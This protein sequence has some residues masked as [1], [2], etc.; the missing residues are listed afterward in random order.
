MC[1]LLRFIAVG[2]I[3]FPLL[4]VGSQLF[5]DAGMKEFSE[6]QLIEVG[7]QIYQQG[8]LPNGEPVKAI[9]LGNV[10]V[11]GEQFTC[12]NCHRRSGLGGP[13]GTKYVLPANGASLVVP[14]VDL[15][16]SRPAYSEQSFAAALNSGQNPNGEDFDPIMPRYELSERQLTALFTYLKTL[17]SDFSPGLTDE[18]LNVATI[19][20]SDVSSAD[21]QAMLSVINK[22]FTNKNA[23]TRHENKRYASGPFYQEY[24]NKAYRRWN[25]HLWELSGPAETWGEQLDAYYQ[26]QPVFAIVSGM[27]TGSWEPIHRFSKARQIPCILPNT[28]LPKIEKVND[29]YTLYYS[30]GLALEAKVLN[31][32]LVS[33]PAGGKILQIYRTGTNGAAAA[34]TMTQ[35]F[36]VPDTSLADFILPVGIFNW[37]EVAKSI[38]QLTPDLLI[39][40]LSPEDL[41]AFAAE[42]T[43]AVPSYLSSSLLDG[44][45]AAIPD[46]LAETAQLIHP[47]NL[48]EDHPSRFLRVSAWM[49]VNRVPL[50]NPRLQGQT[51]YACML[52]N[53]GMKH[54]KR[55]FYR[56]FFLDLL[57]HGERMAAYSG[58][59]PRLSFGPEQRFLAKGAYIVDLKQNQAEW[60][61][62]Q[63]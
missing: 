22:F 59:Y 41:T 13:E 32:R 11:S 51:Y 33:N 30:K 29:F 42:V 28:D 7:R 45:F 16:M 21:R 53:A 14:R 34:V 58:N 44:D 35:N 1:S 48:P 54:I 26:Q 10:E 47:F 37:D 12:L 4:L 36:S 46:S 49:K 61:V 5:A 17:S 27:V 55:Y 60:I 39:L 20:S 40:W 18:V 2:A 57:D 23:E 63:R 8:R 62:P 15:Y 38:R 6:Q 31:Q 56:E 43:V 9:V 3:F 24:R 52:L 19:V 50:T 25:L